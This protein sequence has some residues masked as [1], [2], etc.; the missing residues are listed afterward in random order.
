[1]DVPKKNKVLIARNGVYAI[2]VTKTAGYQVH[3]INDGN[4]KFDSYIKLLSK[5]IF[6]SASKLDSIS[7]LALFSSILI[8]Q[9]F[10]ILINSCHF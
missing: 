5:L 8:L 4:S 9:I 3:T 7:L 10:L 6:N 1:M 2:P